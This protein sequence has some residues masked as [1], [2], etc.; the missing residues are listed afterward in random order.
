[1]TRGLLGRRDEARKYADRLLAVDPAASIARFKQLME[2]LFQRNPDALARF[3]E[4]ARS[5]G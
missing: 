5:A 3:L 4:G 2:K 1:M